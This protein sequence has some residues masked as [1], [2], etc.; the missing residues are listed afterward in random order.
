LA[1]MTC[2][3]SVIEGTKKRNAS[4]PSHIPALCTLRHIFTTC[5]DI[6][7]PPKKVS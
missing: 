4:V 3:I 5:L 7:E 6:R 1:D 2:S